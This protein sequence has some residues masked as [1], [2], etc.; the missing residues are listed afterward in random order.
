M[1]AMIRGSKV[2]LKNIGARSLIIYGLATDYCVC[3]TVLHALEENFDVTLLL[4]LS[5]GITPE[6]TRTAI[7]EM[8]AA[9]AKIEE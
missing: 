8:K 4:G 6:G 3:A 2:S 5:R 9:G 1:E 7:E